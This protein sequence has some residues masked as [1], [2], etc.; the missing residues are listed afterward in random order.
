MTDKVELSET[1]TLGNPVSDPEK[2]DLTLPILL[3]GKSKST[4]DELT[5]SHFKHFC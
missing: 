2:F 1:S 5:V 3:D 4:N